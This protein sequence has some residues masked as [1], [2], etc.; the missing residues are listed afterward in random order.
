MY[1]L[2]RQLRKHLGTARGE[3]LRVPPQAG[4]P[5]AGNEPGIG[6]E[7]ARGW[8]LVSLA[9]RQPPARRPAP[10]VTDADGNAD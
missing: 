7:Q 5:A 4:D 8:R 2:A 6:D 3:P 1:L 9:W 10:T